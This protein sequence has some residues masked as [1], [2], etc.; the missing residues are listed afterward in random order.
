MKRAQTDI[1]CPSFAK[2]NEV[3]DDI[4]D[5]GCIKN[6]I[7]CSPVYHNLTNEITKL[8]ILG[9]NCLLWAKLFFCECDT[10]EGF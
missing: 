5:V 2:V 4:N 10:C 8:A 9:Q 1:V 3:G 7:N 6:L